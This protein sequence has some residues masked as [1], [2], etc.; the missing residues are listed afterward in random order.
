MFLVCSTWFGLS[1]VHPH[2]EF[3]TRDLAPRLKNGGFFSPTPPEVYW[4]CPAIE[5]VIFAVLSP[6][7]SLKII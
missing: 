4:R 3:R 7:N 2:P 1:F 5:A 6:T